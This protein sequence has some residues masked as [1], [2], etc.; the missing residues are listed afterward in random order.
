MEEGENMKTG[1]EINLDSGVTTHTHSHTHT[2]RA[3]KHGSSSA[4]FLP[5]YYMSMDV[6]IRTLPEQ[7]CVE[8]AIIFFH[9]C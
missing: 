9:S 6:Y 1:V 2:A 7:N 3:I 5:T 8:D 4:S